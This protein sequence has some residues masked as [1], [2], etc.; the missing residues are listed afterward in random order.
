MRNRYSACPDCGGE[1]TIRASRCDPCYRKMRV[2]NH[3]ELKVIAAPVPDTTPEPEPKS[4]PLDPWHQ[5]P[6]LVPARTNP[7]LPRYRMNIYGEWEVVH[8]RRP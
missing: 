1:K 5:P 7:R 6:A 3:N 2:A 8:E 4:A